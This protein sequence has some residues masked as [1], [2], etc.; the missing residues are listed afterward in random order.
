MRQ[1]IIT[2]PEGRHWRV[3]GV[4][5][6]GQYGPSPV[7]RLVFREESTGEVFACPASRSLDRLTD[8]ELADRLRLLLQHTRRSAPLAMPGSYPGAA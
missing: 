6:A 1:R 5:A 4:P 2:D 7:P 3:R 8:T